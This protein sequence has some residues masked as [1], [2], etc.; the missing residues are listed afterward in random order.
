MGGATKSVSGSKGLISQIFT[1]LANVIKSTGQAINNILKGIG[2]AA[3]GVAAI[4]KATGQ[5]I[6]STLKG[7]GPA[8]KGLGQGLA[9]AFKGIG[10]RT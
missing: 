2:P 4:I 5:A 9:A 1:G 10:A 7:I 3:K 8:A 6:N